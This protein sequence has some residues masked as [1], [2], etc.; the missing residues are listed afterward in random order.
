MSRR[1][2]HNIVIPILARLLDR[3]KI[4]PYRSGLHHNVLEDERLESYLEKRLCGYLAIA[5][6]EEAE[7]CPKLE[8]ELTRMLKEDREGFEKLL[9][10]L[11]VDYIREY[12]AK[13]LTPE[14]REEIVKKL[15]DMFDDQ[16]PP[17]AMKD[18]RKK[19]KEIYRVIPAPYCG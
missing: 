14:E 7:Y 5:R 10:R 6:K 4:L 2:I 9:E 19:W 18:L 8:E 16:G 13:D 17:D 3:S 15:V 11:L 1:I 12:E